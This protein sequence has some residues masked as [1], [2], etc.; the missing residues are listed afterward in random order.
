M[1]QL[2]PSGVTVLTERAGGG[3]EAFGSDYIKTEKV[4][5]AVLL[6]GGP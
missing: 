1:N 2:A 5:Q 4:R 3:H 6:P